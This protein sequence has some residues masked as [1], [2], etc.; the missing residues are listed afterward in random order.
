[1]AGGPWQPLRTEHWVDP[2][3]ALLG[4][5]GELAGGE[6]AV[7]QILEPRSGSWP[8]SRWLGHLIF[9]LAAVGEASKIGWER[10]IR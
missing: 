7:V 3:R 2:L 5:A 1:M 8:A 6:T 4:A 9:G 10:A